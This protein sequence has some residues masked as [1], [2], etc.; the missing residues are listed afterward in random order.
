MDDRKTAILLAVIIT[1]M[2]VFIG[3][4]W[5]LATEKTKLT[6]VIDPQPNLS[7]ELS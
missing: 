6:D 5:Y 2:V 4:L 7:E 1:A 3:S